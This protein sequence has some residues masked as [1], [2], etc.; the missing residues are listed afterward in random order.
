[1]NER[2]NIA[3]YAALVDA[4]VITEN[5]KVE[6]ECKKRENISKQLNVRVVEFEDVDKGPWGLYRDTY[7]RQQSYR[8]Y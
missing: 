7:T 2:D 6:I 5:P 3:K 8:N 4:G 1:M